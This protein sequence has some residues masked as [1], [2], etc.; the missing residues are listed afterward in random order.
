MQLGERS[1]L[2]LGLV[3]LTAMA[4]VTVVALA[5][6]RS[7]LVGGTRIEASFTDANGLRPGDDVL[8]AGV[9]AG[10]VVDV[11]IDGDHVDAQLQVE[12]AELPV[13]TRAEIALR[14]LVGRRVVEL[15]TGNDFSELLTEG[16]TIPLERTR[17]AVDVPELGEDTRELLG[18]T[19]AEALNTF[20]RSVTDVTADQREELAAL[21]DGSSRLSKVVT[22]QEEQIRRLLRALRQVSATLADRDEELVAIID[23]FGVVLDRLAER[24]EEVRRLLRETNATSG[25][26]ADLAAE[27]RAQLDDVLDEVH[28]DLAVLRRHQVDLAEALAYAPASLGG[29][30]EIT[31]AGTEPVPFGKVFVSSLGPL[32]VDVLLGC[33]GLFDQQLDALLGPDPRP[34]EEQTN[35]RFPRE[36]EEQPSPVPGAPVPG[37][38]SSSAPAGESGIDVLARRLLPD[39]G[40][41]G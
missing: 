34:C 13:D 30:A 7:D 16:D 1:P 12:G 9:R 6:Q 4:A 3:A 14:T 35:R 29:F 39:S 5:V 41:D 10:E 25:E 15:D 17:V 20:L 24:R 36:G 28:A 22:D 19:D 32:G 37:P 11:A 40:G 38:G 23:D 33:G 31:F 21:I 8:V 26:A 2:V 18:G 27:T